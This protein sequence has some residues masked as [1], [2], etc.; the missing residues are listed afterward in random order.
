VITAPNFKREWLQRGDG[1]AFG[2]GFG[3]GFGKGN[4]FGKGKGNSFGYGFGSGDTH[5]TVLLNP[6]YLERM[7]VE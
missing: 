6:K 5:R 1:N 2:N 3:Y 4:G 7:G